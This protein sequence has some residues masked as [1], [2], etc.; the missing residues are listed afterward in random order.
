[1]LD[2]NITT[3][4]APGTGKSS[5]IHA[6]A[7]EL[8][9]EIYF[10]SLASPGIDDYSLGRL[11]SDTPSKCILVIED[12]DCAFPSRDEPDDEDDEEP[13]RDR[14]GNPIKYHPL[15][16]PK[17]AATL[18][19]L[20]NVLDSVS[21]EEGRLTFATVRL[22]NLCL[23]HC[24]IISR[25]IISGILILIRAG[26]M[27]IKIHYGLAATEQI[28][29]EEENR[30]F[31]APYTDED[32]DRYTAEFAA[33]IPSEMYSIAQVQGYLLTKKQ[34]VPAAVEGVQEWLFAQQM[35]PR[36]ISDAKRRW[37]EDLARWRRGF[38]E[39]PPAVNAWQM[40]IGGVAEPEQ[41]V[42]APTGGIPSAAVSVADIVDVLVAPRGTPGDD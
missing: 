30:R 34:D 8:G 10:I 15:M 33:A 23:H 26:R 3:D 5:T 6:I 25:Q 7:G 42:P 31:P 41:P 28:E 24:L 32:L 13:E 38:E 12:I 36:A 29:Q 22:S 37:R 39:P 16:P 19:G 2:C 9:L 1:M 17:S 40:V 4:G 21:S 11:I 20:L 18:S 27:N 14:N 35:E